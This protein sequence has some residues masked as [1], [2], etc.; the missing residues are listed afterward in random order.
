MATKNEVILK[1]NGD[2]FLGVIDGN[3][4]GVLNSAIYVTNQAKIL[5]PTDKGQL[6]NSI[7]YKSGKSQS[8]G[9]NNN[10]GEQAPEKI[11][12]QPKENEAYVGTNLDYGIY[13][14]FGTRRMSAQPYL[15]PAGESL[16][17]DIPAKQ[18]KDA[19]AKALKKGVKTI[20][21]KSV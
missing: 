21:F 5:A 9:F 7:M 20:R 12:V 1:I 17:I 18:Q 15:R 13:Q 4:R 14:E 6:R 2:P 3:K 16:N 8:G 10:A 19:M 11:H